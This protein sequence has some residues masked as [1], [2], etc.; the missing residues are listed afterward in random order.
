M[1]ER[2]PSQNYFNRENSGDK[3]LP[4]INSEAPTTPKN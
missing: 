4:Y 1:G 2:V 3:K